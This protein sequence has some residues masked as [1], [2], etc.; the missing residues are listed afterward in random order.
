VLQPQVPGLP[1]LGGGVRR[2][3]SVQDVLL[4]AYTY[5]PR[6]AHHHSVGEV[7]PQP[8]PS[9]H[10]VVLHI[11]VRAILQEHNGGI[12][13]VHSSCPVQGRLA[14]RGSGYR[15]GQGQTRQPSHIPASWAASWAYPGRPRH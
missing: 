5:V 11:L 15:V 10:L 4:A 12:H 3:S 7:T 9:A 13:V 1:A 2:A 8:Q 14:W 6:N